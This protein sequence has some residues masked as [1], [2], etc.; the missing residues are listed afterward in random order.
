MKIVAKTDRAKTREEC[1][2][3]LGRTHQVLKLAYKA[4][5]LLQL[6]HGADVV[7]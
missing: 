7:V 6:V 1:N 5:K 4:E 2:A 3:L